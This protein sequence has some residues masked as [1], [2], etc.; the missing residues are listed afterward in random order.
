MYKRGWFVDIFVENRD[1]F[2]IF[3]KH[4]NI[5]T[6][7]TYPEINKT[8]MYYD[9]SIFINSHYISNNGLFLPTHMKLTNDEILYICNIIKLF[10]A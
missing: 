7:A 3:L 4:H 9:D 8:P 1:K 6:R 2:I 5:Q 10:L